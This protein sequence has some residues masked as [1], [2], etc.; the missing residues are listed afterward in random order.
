[1]KLYKKQ[2]RPMIQSPALLHGCNSTPY[3]FDGENTDWYDENL[4][5]SL[6]TIYTKRLKDPMS[7]V[8]F[9]E[10]YIEVEMPEPEVLKVNPGEIVCFKFDPDVVDI[11]MVSDYASRLRGVLPDDTVIML[12]PA[13]NPEVM[14]KETAY[15]MLD[16]I[17]ERL[18]DIYQASD[19]NEDA[20]W[21][22][23]DMS[24]MR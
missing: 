16:L 12:A 24:R 15:K 20:E 7:R 5:N 17:K 19:E 10:K 13:I 9:D 6:L 14:D 18:D 1:M 8:V 4:R 23:Y 22:D 21:L 2:I 3:P 11:D